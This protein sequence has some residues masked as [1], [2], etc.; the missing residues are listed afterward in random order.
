M[1]AIAEVRE[2]YDTGYQKAYKNL[3]DLC[4]HL[5]RI[6]DALGNR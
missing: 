3:P 2:E 1:T 6:L 5:E 4:D